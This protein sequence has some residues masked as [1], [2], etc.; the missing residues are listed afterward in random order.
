MPQ[1]CIIDASEFTL[2]L[3]WALLTLGSTINYKVSMV[4]LGESNLCIILKSSAYPI[5]QGAPVL[6]LEGW[7]ATQFAG[8]PAQRH[9]LKLAI[10]W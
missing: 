3:R 9:L 1:L 6:V 8:F 4:H 7:P 5:Q 2:T 10:S